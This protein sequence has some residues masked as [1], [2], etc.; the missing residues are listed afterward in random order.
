MTG[1]RTKNSRDIFLSS[2]NSIDK[3]NQIG[4]TE[5][6]VLMLVRKRTDEERGTWL[7][8]NLAT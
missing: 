4:K 2:R 6:E 1:L 3:T 5:F 8:Q 7:S